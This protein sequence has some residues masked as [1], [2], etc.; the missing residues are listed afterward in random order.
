MKLLTFLISL[1]SLALTAPINT[2]PNPTAVA[3][4]KLDKRSNDCGTPTFEN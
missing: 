2:T 3:V 4:K 1:V